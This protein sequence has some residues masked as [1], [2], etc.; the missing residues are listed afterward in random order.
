MGENNKIVET[1]YEDVIKPKYFTVSDASKKLNIST[2]KINHWIF[3]LNKSKSNFFSNTNKLTEDDLDKIALA[4]SLHDEGSSF[5]EIVNYFTDESNALINK[6]N[7]SIKTDLTKL[8]SQVLSKALT[9][10]V[11]KNINK[12]IETLENDFTDRITEEFRQQASNIAGS[13][14]KAI[15]KTKNEMLNE[16]I[17][18]RKQNHMFKNEIERMYSNQTEELRKKLEEKEKNIKELEKQ[19]NKSWFSKIFKR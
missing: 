5:E 19:K 4:Q 11:E 3:K 12:L 1:S 16:V 18:L 9:M 17:E 2:T 6:D 15:E 8:D 7:N 10:E 13:S 14:L